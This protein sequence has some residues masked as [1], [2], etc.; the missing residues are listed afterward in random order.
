[1]K[2]EIVTSHFAPSGFYYEWRVAKNLFFKCIENKNNNWYFTISDNIQFSIDLMDFASV[3]D[4]ADCERKFLVVSS[5]Y[6]CK[7]IIFNA[8]FEKLNP[9]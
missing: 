4:A 3:K 6:Y 2:F 9:R 8:I 1:M 7:K 5:S